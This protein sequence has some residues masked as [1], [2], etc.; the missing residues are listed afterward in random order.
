MALHLLILEHPSLRPHL[1]AVQSLLDQAVASV[2]GVI[3]ELRDAPIR[4]FDLREA[5]DEAVGAVQAAGLS[6]RLEME[7]VPDLP[8]EVAEPLALVAGEAL[9]NVKKH[10]AAHTV[11]VRLAARGGAA[12]LE[13]ADDGCGSPPAARR[14]SRRRR[15][16]GLWL[17]SEQ[18]RR[19]GGRLEVR[20][21]P[22]GGTLVRA[23]IPI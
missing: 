20:R 23:I 21:R 7:G 6:V 10:A 4:S 8:G 12:V 1:V 5:L 2:R 14:S 18:V 15:S 16:F 17:M 11:S 3:G 19:L 13:V 22:E 9:E